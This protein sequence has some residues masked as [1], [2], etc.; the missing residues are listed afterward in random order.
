[1]APV[2]VVPAL[3]EVEDRDARL[4]VVTE[5]SSIEQLA[6]QRGE[7]ALAHRVVIAIT[8]RAH[9]RS[10]SGMATPYPELDRGVLAAVIG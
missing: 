9:R 3:D 10:D 1:M 6:F 5:T 2:R 4:I 8:A 7:E